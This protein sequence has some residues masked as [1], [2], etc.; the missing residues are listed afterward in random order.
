MSLF[1]FCYF[2]FNYCFIP[3]KGLPWATERGDQNGLGETDQENDVYTTTPAHDEYE[4]RP[5]EQDQY[6][7][8]QNGVFSEDTKYY[9]LST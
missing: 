6:G 4:E 7:Q 8:N 5:S 3:L 2:C 9:I 1:L